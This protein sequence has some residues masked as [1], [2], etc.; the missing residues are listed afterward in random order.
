MTK[1]L[2]S[3]L[4][5]ED[6]YGTILEV[7]ERGVQLLTPTHS[8]R[9]ISKPHFDWLTAKLFLFPST[10]VRTGIYTEDKSGHLILPI[11]FH[12]EV[13]C[14]FTDS[15]GWQTEGPRVVLWA[16]Q[17]RATH[18]QLADTPSTPT[19]VSGEWE[20]VCEYFSRLCAQKGLNEQLGSDIL[21]ASGL[22]DHYAALAVG[23]I[24]LF[25]DIWDCLASAQAREGQI[26]ARCFALQQ[27]ILS[28]ASPTR[29]DSLFRT[30]DP[31]PPLLFACI[32][33]LEVNLDPQKLCSILQDTIDLA[34]RKV[35]VTV[36]ADKSCDLE[37]WHFLH[38]LSHDLEAMGATLRLRLLP[39]SLTLTA[40]KGIPVPVT[41]NL[42]VSRF[43]APAFFDIPLRSILPQQGNLE[44][45]ELWEKQEPELRGASSLFDLLTEEVYDL[46]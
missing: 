33:F 6:H 4:S 25:F 38:Q 13:S 2:D 23:D 16:P 15:Q 39:H 29:T 28:A 31:L 24:E 43:G 45:Q 17:A 11:P 21:T 12:P 1:P 32:P 26:I 41:P 8:S 46:G 35:V 18:S 10:I 34:G 7:E 19:P 37:Y 14:A 22:A 3:V 5:A 27:N 42:L 20:V 9:P 44:P 36:V 40:S 30:Y